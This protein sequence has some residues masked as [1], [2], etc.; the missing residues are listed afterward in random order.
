M[1]RYELLR[2]LRKEKGL[3]LAELGAKAGFTP[4]FLSQLERGLKQPSLDAMRRIA[5][6]LGV[7]ILSLLADQMED[8]DGN[9]SKNAHCSI[10]RNG[11]RQR[12]SVEN[13][14]TVFEL[15]TPQTGDDSRRYT[16]YGVLA[17]TEPGMWTN[18][19]PVVHFYEEC[20]YVLGG[21]MRAFVG[22]EIY[23]LE[24]GDSIYIDGSAPHNYLN[25]GDEPL[26]MLAF[27]SK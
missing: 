14:T 12:F 7:S 3:T 15:I 23:D 1:V 20:C 5:N 19:K 10:I 21:K 18:Q 6:C 17:S 2:T 9:V 4:S 13:K 24:V 8:R 11:K 26:V 27:Q 25:T 16:M 22:E